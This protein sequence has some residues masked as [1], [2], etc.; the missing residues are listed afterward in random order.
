M[1]VKERR[2]INSTSV[3]AFPNAALSTRC[4]CCVSLTTDQFLV[5]STVFKCRNKSRPRSSRVCVDCQSFLSR[6]DVEDIE[7][8]TQYSNYKETLQAI[9]QKIGDVETEA[10]EHKYVF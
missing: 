9:A 8:Q 5:D 1:I 2:Q 6:A 3:L 7:L 10:E 4:L